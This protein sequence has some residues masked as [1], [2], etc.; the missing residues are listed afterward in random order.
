MGQNSQAIKVADVYG[1]GNTSASE[2]KQRIQRESCSTL[3]FL[4]LIDATTQRVISP[5]RETIMVQPQ[6]QPA[7]DSQLPP[8]S[9]H[10]NP[11]TPRRLTMPTFTASPTYNP[12]HTMRFG[13]G[14]CTHLTMTRLY[15]T[16]Y[17]CSICL[18]I[19]SMGWVY[20][21]TQ[22]RELLIEEDME[23]GNEVSSL[24]TISDI[25]MLKAK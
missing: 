5:A 10:P 14:Q 9:T 15:T 18:R 3:Q 21:C 4:I 25:Q 13:N 24:F 2:F 11:P 12:R 6:P 7:N 17:R 19:G 22:D 1:C 23:R 20:R 16:E 8:A